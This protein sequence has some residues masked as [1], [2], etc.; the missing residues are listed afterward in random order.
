MT[1]SSK[2]IDN[3]S[4][5]RA[6]TFEKWTRRETTGFSLSGVQVFK[7]ESRERPRIIGS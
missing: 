2:V 1:A 5:G 4:E 6:T 3:K 7:R